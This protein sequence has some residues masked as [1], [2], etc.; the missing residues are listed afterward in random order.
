MDASQLI[1]SI[2]SVL[3][4]K[5]YSAYISCPNYLIHGYEL[6][7]L[8]GISRIKD[9]SQ[10]RFY[11]N[12]NLIQ[13]LLYCNIRPL[14]SHNF[15]NQDKQGTQKTKKELSLCHKLRFLNPYIFRTQC[16]RPQIFQTMNCVSSSDLCLKYQRFTPLGCQDISIRKFE[17]VTKTQFLF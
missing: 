1:I 4:P 6:Q 9:T 10:F 5:C 13:N 3:L 2:S 7:I 8:Q 15:H 14:N 16:H 17:F 12:L 11:F